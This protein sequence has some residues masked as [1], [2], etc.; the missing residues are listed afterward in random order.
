MFRDT[1]MGNLTSL[2]DIFF[3]FLL[4]LTDIFFQWNK[5]L[6]LQMSHDQDSIFAKDRVWV[7]GKRK[8][9]NTNLAPHSQVKIR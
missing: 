5:N 3:D 8:I 7:A 2:T 4:V 1:T 9:C 6:T